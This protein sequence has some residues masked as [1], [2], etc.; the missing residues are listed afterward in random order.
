MRRLY[1][2]FD[3][4]FMC[5]SP[6]TWNLPRFECQNAGER[7]ES[8]VGT[9]MGTLFAGSLIQAFPFSM[10]LSSAVLRSRP[11]FNGQVDSLNTG[12]KVA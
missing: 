8:H 1:A 7:R 3:S 11:I 9:R 10:I 4:R 5:V 12:V 6:E 2:R